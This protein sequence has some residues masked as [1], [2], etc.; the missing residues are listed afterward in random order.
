MVAAP[1]G[2][3]ANLKKDWVETRE[4]AHSLKQSIY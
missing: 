2:S 4:L 1:D 3:N